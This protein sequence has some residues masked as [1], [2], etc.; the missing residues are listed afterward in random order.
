VIASIIAAND[1]AFSYAPDQ[2][3]RMWI[4]ERVSGIALGSPMDFEF[5]ANQDI[6]YLARL[7]R[8][9]SGRP[10]LSIGGIHAV[11]SLGAVHFLSDPHSFL[12]LRRT[13]GSGLFSMVTSCAFTRAPL[14]I[15]TSE[16]LAPPRPHVEVPTA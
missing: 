6:C 13:V 10:F 16:V 15:L 5:P 4:T 9:G 8:P 1:P 3:R 11:G 12:E 2:A 7:P 14:R